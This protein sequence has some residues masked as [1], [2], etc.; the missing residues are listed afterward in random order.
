[1]DFDNYYIASTI[2]Q[3]LP[4]SRKPVEVKELKKERRIQSGW[5]HQDNYKNKSEDVIGLIKKL[6][7]LHSAGLLTDEEFSNKK[8]ELLAKI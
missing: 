3:L 6:G 5:S 7:D 2:I 4:E 8:A 1:M